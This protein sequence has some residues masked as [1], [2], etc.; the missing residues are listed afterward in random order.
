MNACALIKFLQGECKSTEVITLLL[1]T[2]G[3]KLF[4]L[5]RVLITKSIIYV[6]KS[7]L[8]LIICDE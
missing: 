4:K 5:N 7:I 1:N 8:L 6:I 3:I 2:V